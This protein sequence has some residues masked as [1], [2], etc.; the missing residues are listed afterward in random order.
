METR[1][2]KSLTLGI[3]VCSLA[4]LSLY[5]LSGEQSTVKAEQETVYHHE[6]VDGPIQPIP[7]KIEIDTR[8]ANLGKALFHSTLLSKNNT[9]SCASC[10]LIEFGGDDG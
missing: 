10:H 8:W 2:Y 9:V 4:P 5:L 1:Y 7:R 6:K 3:L